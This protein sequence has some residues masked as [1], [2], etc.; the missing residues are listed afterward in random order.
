MADD[1]FEEMF[2][3]KRNISDHIVCG[4]CG[5]RWEEGHQCSAMPPEQCGYFWFEEDEEDILAVTRDVARET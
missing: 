1:I 2:A 5:V 4:V 3:A